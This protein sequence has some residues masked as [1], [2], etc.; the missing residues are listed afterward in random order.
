MAGAERTGRNR[1]GLTRLSSG[2]GRLGV[3]AGRFVL[4]PTRGVAG[5][6]LEPVAELAVDRALAGPLPEAVARSLVEHR[7][8]ERVVREVMASADFEAAVDA[9]L[10]GENT[11]RLVERVLASPRTEK[12]LTEALESKLT[13]QF[14]ERMVQSPE[15]EHLLTQVMSSPAV[16]NAIAKQTESIGDQMIDSMRRA[17]F[18]QDDRIEG[19][20]RRLFVKP[21]RTAETT[22]RFGGFAS[23]GAALALDSLLVSGAYLIGVA[24]VSVVGHLAGGI[25]P[26]WLADALAALGFV[27]VQIAYFA[28]FWTAAGR[29]PGMHLMGVRVHGPGGSRPGFGRSLVRLVGLWLAIAI[30]LLG[31]LPAL[32]DR[33]RRAL[34]DYL[35][36]T[37]VEYDER[38]LALSA[39]ET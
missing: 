37:T 27:I 30:A 2:V 14:A 18:E 5:D 35:A 19:A 8:I 23:R 33:R 38:T 22:A 36:G 7:V 16:R 17:T 20:A 1:N 29:T 26:A 21:P 34:Q 12:L 13:A 3:G 28:G 31:F 11:E 4:R 10:E 32:A 24:F 25:R 9:A 39:D 15:F 6:V